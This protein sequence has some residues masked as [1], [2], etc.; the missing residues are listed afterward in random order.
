M[1]NLLYIS[2]ENKKYNLDHFSNC[3]IGYIPKSHHFYYQSPL[4]YMGRIN[5]SWNLTLLQTSDHLYRNLEEA[6][7]IQNY[8]KHSYENTLDNISGLPAII[9]LEDYVEY[10]EEEILI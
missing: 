9:D 1:S 6:C 10:D 8:H 4:Y 5:T 2:T 7:L 3:S